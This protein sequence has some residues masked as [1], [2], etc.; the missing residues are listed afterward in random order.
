MLAL[1]AGWQGVLKVWHKSVGNLR[2]YWRNNGKIKNMPRSYR[3]TRMLCIKSMW[4]IQT[5][6]VTITDHLKKKK[7]SKAGLTRD[8]GGWTHFG[9]NGQ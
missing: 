9:K 1:L 5:F 4:S 7:N 3:T 8:G 6:A 2:L